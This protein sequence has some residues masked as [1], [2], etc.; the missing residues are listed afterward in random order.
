M[1]QLTE[2]SGMSLR[3]VIKRSSGKVERKGNVLK[4][5]NLSFLFRRVLQSAEIIEAANEARMKWNQ[6]V[7]RAFVSGIPEE[8][9]L[10]VKKSEISDQVKKSIKKKG[11]NPSLFQ[12][13]IDLAV[14]ALELIIT[15]VRY[16]FYGADDIERT[17]DE[18]IEAMREY[19]EAPEWKE[20][21]IRLRRINGELRI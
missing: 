6:T 20:E 8:Q 1:K 17:V 21:Y 18:T 10:K 12:R 4:Q 7:D 2:N 15:K 13:I 11:D 14:K 5:E 9:I 19:P 16:T 3:N